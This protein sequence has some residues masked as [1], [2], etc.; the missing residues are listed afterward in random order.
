MEDNFLNRLHEFV[1]ALQCIPGTE[2][3]DG[4]HKY[5]DNIEYSIKIDTGAAARKHK[6]ALKEFLQSNIRVIKNPCKEMVITGFIQLKQGNIKVDM[7]AIW[8]LLTDDTTRSDFLQWLYGVI[9][10]SDLLTLDYPTKEKEVIALFGEGTAPDENVAETTNE[11]GPSLQDAFSGDTKEDK[12]I[13]EFMGTVQNNTRSK[14]PMSAMKNLM[15]PNNLKT[16]AS[17]MA[18]KKR[19]IKVR[20][21]VE[22]LTQIIPEDAEF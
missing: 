17:L 3:M 4:L 7:G 13:R 21:V 2:Q 14:N 10:K 20:K 16:I 12:F 11:A 6:Q 22:R 9:E 5:S 19:G 8:L 1:M 15:N 18:G